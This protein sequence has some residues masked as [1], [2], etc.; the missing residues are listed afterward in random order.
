MNLHSPS[1]SSG[2]SRAARGALRYMSPLQTDAYLLA[3]D[4]VRRIQRS[5]ALLDMGLLAPAGS[6]ARGERHRL[7]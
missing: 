2:R 5:S 4:A 3:R 1:P 6:A 7:H